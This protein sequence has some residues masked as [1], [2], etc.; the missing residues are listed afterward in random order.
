MEPM[1]PA[2]DNINP[3]RRADTALDELYRLRGQLLSCDPSGF[4]LDRWRGHRDALE[5]LDEAISLVLPYL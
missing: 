5:G 2:N 4:T 3:L 1:Q